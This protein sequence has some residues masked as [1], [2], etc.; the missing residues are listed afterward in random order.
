MKPMVAA[1][2]EITLLITTLNTNQTMIACMMTWETKVSR[3]D[4]MFDDMGNKVEQVSSAQQGTKSY[5]TRNMDHDG[6]QTKQWHKVHCVFLFH[7]HL[8]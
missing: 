8:I 5:S 3:Y 2:K 1:V 6:G 7:F 4:D